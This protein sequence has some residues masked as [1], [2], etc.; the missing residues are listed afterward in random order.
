MVIEPSGWLAGDDNR[1]GRVD[2]DDRRLP[3]IVRVYGVI[4]LAD[5]LLTL[6]RLVLS[7]L[8]S[9]REFLAGR[10][11]V[12]VLNLTFILT[13]MDT[14]VLVVNSAL[15]II[16][17]ILLLRNRRRHA[18]RWAYVLLP[19]T[20][21]EAMLSLALL[22]LGPNL[23]VPAVQIAILVTLS[24][25]ADPALIE[26]R[27]LKY[28][29]R[30]MDERDSYWDAVRSGMLGRDATGKGYI[31]LD[32]FNVFWL[33][34]IGCVFGLAVETVYHLVVYGEYQDR[35]GLLFGP[36]SPIYGFGAVILT[37]CLNRLWRANPVFIFLASAVI[38]G[39]FEYAVSWFMEAA[40]GIKAWDYT[41]RWLSIGGRTSGLYMAFWGVLGVLW[42][43]VILQWILWLINKI[44]WK[45]RY[46][47]TA[48]C[49]VL[50]VADCLFTLMAFDCWY[51]RMAG[52][53]PD[54]PVTAWFAR[55]FG[56]EFMAHRFQTMQ[57]DPS[58]AGRL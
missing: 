20:G 54:S 24:V 13:C 29:L 10:A 15:L 23:I 41:G 33:F 22:G 6:P 48:V 16:F 21:L 50:M 58:T 46:S 17:G 3:L 37:A 30:R 19:L 51:M 1:D 34:V 35:A 49:L 45:V 47:L 5:G 57:L 56:N 36:F 32:F 28:A 52:T 18:A 7:A 9:V 43:K 11:Q 8:Q 53:A 40:F 42:I 2:I 39:A 26:E 27:R 44:P 31:S 12:D 4:V 14:V 38:G 55:H 25:A